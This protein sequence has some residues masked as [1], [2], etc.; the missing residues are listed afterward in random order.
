MNNS[1][2]SQPFGAGDKQHRVTALI[3]RQTSKAPQ[4]ALEYDFFTN[5]DQTSGGHNNYDTQ[6]VYADMQHWF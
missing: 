1:A 6:R 3:T 5:H 2:A 4:V